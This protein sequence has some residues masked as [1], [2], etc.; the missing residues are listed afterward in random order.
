MS[1]PKN[2]VELEIDFANTHAEHYKRK[3]WIIKATFVVA[4]VIGFLML[5]WWMNGWKRGDAINS[6]VTEKHRQLNGL[7]AL[8]ENFFLP[9]FPCKIARKCEKCS[10]YQRVLPIFC[11]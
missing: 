1:P 7:K 9:C 11:H 10:F 2:E 3:S 6:Q 8:K 5:D 4:W